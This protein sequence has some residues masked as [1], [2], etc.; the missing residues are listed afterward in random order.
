MGE[1]Y[2]RR[3]FTVEISA[4]LG[5]DGRH[6]LTLRKGSK[7]ILVQCKHWNEWKVSEPSLREFYGRV[8][9]ESANSGIFVTSGAYTH[10]ARSFVEG[11]PLELV[12]RAELEQLL[13][14][15]TA[16]GE[17]IFD[18]ARWVD[19]FAANARVV[20]P[21]CPFCH[22][23]MNLRRSVQG[24]VSW[25]CQSFPKCAGKREGRAEL[26]RAREA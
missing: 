10:D 19:R 26:L 5:A 18:L 21:S 12:G 3:G 17:N 14:E 25:S 8:I 1:I 7:N 9:E 2:R 16:P 15:V 4:G 13:E 24:K 23:P 20:D 22:Q 11:K 6:D